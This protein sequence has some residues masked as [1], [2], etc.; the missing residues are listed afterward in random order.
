[1]SRKRNEYLGRLVGELDAIAAR[2]HELEDLYGTQL[3]LLHPRQK[4]GGLNLLHYLA[5]RH[6]DVRE[7]QYELAS[8]GLSSLGQSESHVLASVYAVQDAIRHLLGLD[9]RRARPPVTLRQ[10][11]IRIRKQTSALFGRKLKGSSVR[12][13]VTLPDEAADDYRL[14]RDMVEAG[15]N[16]ARI[17]CAHGGPTEWE[18]MVSHVHRARAT[19]GRTCRIFMDLCGPKI[20]TGALAAGPEVMR[21]KP[22]TDVRGRVKGPAILHLVPDGPQRT[23]HSGK[24][25]PVSADLLQQLG[26]GDRLE[27]VDTRDKPVS[28]DVLSADAESV[29]IACWSRAYVETGQRLT[30][31][32]TDGDVC[33]EGLIGQL[34]AARPAILL[35][36]GDTLLVHRDPRPGENAQPS[37]EGRPP[38]PAHVSCAVP[39]VF[40]TV[41]VG[42][43]LAFD[44]GK[45][46]GV[47]ID[48]EPGEIMVRIT[49]AQQEG[50]KLRAFKGINLP[51]TPLGLFGLTE[52]D[53][54]DLRFVAEHAEGVN[55]SFVNHPDDVEDLLDELESAGGHHLGLVLKIETR[56]GARHLPGILLAAME[57]P[58]VGVMIARGDL[59]VEVGWTRLARTQEE[60][61]GLCEAAHVPVIWATEVLN[62]LAKKGIP[63]RGEISDVVLAERAEC[64][65]L[66]KGPYITTAIR[67][68]DTILSSV[69]TYQTKKT[70][71]L[72]TLTAET[73]DPTE[74]GRTVGARRGRWQEVPASG[75]GAEAHG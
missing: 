16:C 7:L 11:Q 49:H 39:E 50:T 74:I 54:Q 67:T 70:F 12:I 57:W 35:H 44:D 28:F 56:M 33:A 52:K 55:V 58:A 48:V 13:M 9:S 27:L 14:V 60:I 68:L 25:I 23:T 38:V 31:R 26:P 10:G 4:S 37:V 73:P 63:T 40:E 15:M 46:R 34:Q 20:R 3:G 71:L 41:K 66:N 64:V 2:A 47:V 1:M 59:A 62:R 32:N 53:R 36:I 42:H 19:T 45:V 72:P 65:M 43:E 29:R 21:I 30:L 5:L 6:G 24:S 75:A 8:L 18:R 69:Q 17:N 51:D 22:S 61:L